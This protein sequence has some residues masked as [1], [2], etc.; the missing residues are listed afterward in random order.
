LRYWDVQELV[1]TAWAFAKIGFHNQPLMEEAAV[2][3]ASRLHQYVAR[4]LANTAWAFATLVIVN[5][6]LLS[7]IAAEAPRKIHTGDSQAISNTAWAFATC[8]FDNKPLMDALATT[9]MSRVDDFDEQGCATTAFAF[10][11]L[12]YWQHEPLINALAARAI[13]IMR[14]DTT[15]RTPQYRHLL[16]ALA[17]LVERNLHQI[18]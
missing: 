10:A 12:Q 11:T 16:D 14:E 3:A 5:R 4:D 1:N 7:A 18:D 6:P 9:A 8:L 17:F 2:A 13:T 15:S